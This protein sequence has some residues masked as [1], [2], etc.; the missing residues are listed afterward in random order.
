ME[1]IVKNKM[2]KKITTEKIK[3]SNTGSGMEEALNLTEEIAGTMELNQKKKFQARLL[4]EEMF[5][6]VRAIAGTFDAEYWLECES[7]SCTYHLEAKSKLDYEKRREFLSVSTKGENIAQRGI[8]EKIREVIEAGV[9]GMEEGLAIQSEYGSGMMDYGTLYMDGM[10]VWSMQKYKSEVETSLS[11]D[12]EE[13]DELEKSIIANI[14]DEVK[15]G[16]N[17]DK[18]EMIIQKKF[19]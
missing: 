9:H 6:M 17:K 13:W 16:V 1:N 18:I 3:I 5:S 10:Y 2:V 4:A 12:S 14:A 15:V 8:M 11:E 19:D 7:E